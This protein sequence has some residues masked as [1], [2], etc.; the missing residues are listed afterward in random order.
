MVK[1]TE[2]LPCPFCGS[3]PHF[4]GDVSDWKDDS[5]YVELTLTCCATMREAIGWRKARDMSVGE[6]YQELRIKL[7]EVWNRRAPEKENAP[8]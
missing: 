3:E 8:Q 7:T 4:E 2:P 5:R 1:L 6:R